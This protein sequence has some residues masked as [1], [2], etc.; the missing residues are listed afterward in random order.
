M[1]N[2]HIL[3]VSGLSLHHHYDYNRMACLLI[4]VCNDIRNY[5]QT[6]KHHDHV[7]NL[8]LQLRGVSVVS[9]PCLLVALHMYTPVSSA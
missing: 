4:D 5:Q 3:S 9:E 7:C 2:N 8:P 1:I 6:I